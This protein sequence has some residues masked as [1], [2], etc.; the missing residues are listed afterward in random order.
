[1]QVSETSFHSIP[2]L[3]WIALTVP[4]SGLVITF[5][6]SVENHQETIDFLRGFSEIDIGPSGGS[7]LAIVVDSESKRQD[8][9][10][11]TAIRD[12]PGVI[13]LAVAMIAFDD[14]NKIPSNNPIGKHR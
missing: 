8:Q 13:D 7:K 1:M 9:E 12:R 5:N 2:E 6:S 4:I 3:F 11:W 10:L 14:D